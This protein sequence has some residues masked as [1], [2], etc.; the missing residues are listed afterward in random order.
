MPPWASAWRLTLSVLPPVPG[1]TTSRFEH[2]NIRVIDGWVLTRFKRCRRYACVLVLFGQGRSDLVT[3]LCKAAIPVG[4]MAEVAL[5]FLVT[6][7]FPSPDNRTLPMFP[8]LRFCVHK[9]LQWLFSIWQISRRNGV[10]HLFLAL[11][12]KTHRSDR[13]T[14]ESEIVFKRWVDI[15]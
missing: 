9:I 15:R 6:S 7:S 14:N 3:W 12:S 1:I 5:A 10:Q 2:Q 4:G 13:F 8:K 11:E